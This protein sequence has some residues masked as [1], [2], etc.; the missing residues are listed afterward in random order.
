[1]TQFYRV[2]GCVRDQILGIKAKDIDYA[3]EAKSFGEMREAILAR[4]GKIYLETPE[5]LTIRA[6]IPEIGD[7]DFVLCRKDGEYHDGRHPEN[8]EPGSLM[9]DLSRRDFTMNAMAVDL[10]GNIID[11]F[12]GR[13]SLESGYISCVGEACE[14]FREDGLRILRAIRFSITKGMAL[15]SDIVVCLYD[16]EYV[17]LL[18]S[19][20]VERIREELLK[21]FKYDTLA[22]WKAL[23]RF[24]KVR[25]L[26]FTTT[27]LWLMPT[28]K[29]K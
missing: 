14:R 28:M 24:D 22:T 12:F 3:V 5:Y 4:G 27:D 1:M 17:Q 21:C 16:K 6:K 26:I 29:E 7:A 20:S 15:D 2:G 10:E 8:V 9:D 23:T 18:K 19:I 25:D 11:P 13:E